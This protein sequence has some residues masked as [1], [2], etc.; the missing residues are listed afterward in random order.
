MSALESARN[1]GKIGSSLQAA[2]TVYASEDMLLAFAGQ[3]AASLFITSSATLTTD[4]A[5]ADAF[6]LE[7]VNDVAVG[8]SLANG[9]KCA[10]CWKVSSEVSVSRDICDRC[11]NVV[12]TLA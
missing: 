9:E 3:D 12:A 10:R 5:P 4:T 7:A 11:Y 2:L 6:W 1:D 8:F